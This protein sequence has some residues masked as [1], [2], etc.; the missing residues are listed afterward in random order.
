MKRLHAASLVSIALAF[1]TATSSAQMVTIRAGSQS[2]FAPD[3]SDPC[4]FATTEQAARLTTVIEADCEFANGAWRAKVYG[5]SGVGVVP[6]DVTGEVK[7][8]VAHFQVDTPDD[9]TSTGYLPIQVV[10]PVSWI[11]RLFN[12]QP[13]PEI[14]I[15]GTEIGPGTEA[16]VNMFL[17]LRQ[18]DAADPNFAGMLVSQQR[19]EGASHGGIGNC[20]SLPT[21]TVGA[22]TM[23]VGCL[24]AV[25]EKEEGS[26]LAQLS[27]VIRTN[28]PYSIELV[29]R[30]HLDS[31]LAIG[32][33]GIPETVNFGRSGIVDDFGLFWSQSAIVRIGTDPN[34]VVSEIRDEIEMLEEE[35][36]LL[37]EEFE[38]HYH[39]YLT[40]RGVGHNNTVAETPPP[41][42]PAP[43]AVEQSSSAVDVVSTSST[44]GAQSQAP[45]ANA[46]AR[47][48]SG[49][50]ALDLLSLLLLIGAFAATRRVT[51]G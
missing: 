18:T 40:G 25:S 24:L 23:A 47:A 6:V 8:I 36:A 15:P 30:G 29:L 42:V 14:N 11:G 35:L 3:A 7:I 43:A 1:V 41:I 20:V 46:D 9:A 31:A 19:F 48:T 28:Q 32:Q 37:R 12:A 44:G 34:V 50:G 13:I 33:N 49:G 39:T 4:F 16:S 27:G 17:R 38:T 45:Q 51:T 5:R 2:A 26:A 10:V 22:L 21:D